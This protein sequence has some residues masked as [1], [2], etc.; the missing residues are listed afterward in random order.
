MFSNFLTY[1]HFTISHHHCLFF[2]LGCFITHPSPKPRKM[3][4][5][6]NSYTLRIQICRE[7]G[8]S[9]V[10]LLWGWDWDHQTY[11]NR[12]GYGSLGISQLPPESGWVI[13]VGG[14][15]RLMRGG[16]YRW[17]ICI[18]RKCCLADGVTPQA[19]KVWGSKVK[20]LKNPDVFLKSKGWSL[21]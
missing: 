12:E 3:S 7:K 17:T 14:S 19:A 6:K 11:S 21:K 8:I 20:Q 5:V 18:E 13:P 15:W 4:P 10:I 9:P 1:E 16:I 2:S